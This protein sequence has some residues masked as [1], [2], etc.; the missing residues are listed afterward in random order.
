MPP[1]ASDPDVVF[2]T[3]DGCT[4]CD[5][6]WRFVPAICAE[7]GLTL[8]AIDVDSDP[9]LVVAHGDWVPVLSIGGVPRLRGVISA[10]WA[11]RELTAYATHKQVHSSAI[12]TRKMRVAVSIVFDADGRVLVN[13]RPEGSYYG[14]WWEW[15]GG[16]CEMGETPLAAAIRELQEEIGI[17]ANDWRPYQRTRTEYPGRSIDLHFLTARWD[18]VSRPHREALEH[19]WLAPRDVRTLRFLEPNLPVLDRLIAERT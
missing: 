11:R 17:V 3:R 4:L 19:Q 2:Y 7:L 10:A 16:K 15:P 14:G 1:A 5:K 12:A 8:S 6:A 18:G 9:K 13:K